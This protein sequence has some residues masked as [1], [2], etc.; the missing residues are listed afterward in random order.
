VS[1]EDPTNPIEVDRYD[2]WPQGE[3]PSYR[4]AWG[5]F[6]H[7]KHNLVYGSNTDGRLYVFT[8][9][10]PNGA[11]VCPIT[12]AGDVNVSGFVT[13]ADIIGLVN[14]VFKSGD[15][16]LP[17]EA[18]GDANCSGDVNAADIISLV[19]YVFKGGTAPCD[20]CGLIP[21]SWSCP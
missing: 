17:C 13:S 1:L 5:V 19:T 16:P 6:P 12:L 4:G 7:N 15:S 11:L 2:T 18:A 10:N 14:Y 8:L 21:D 9:D 3:N 20:V